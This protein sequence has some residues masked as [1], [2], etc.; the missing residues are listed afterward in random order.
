MRKFISILVTICMLCAAM[1][2]FASEN[3]PDLRPH[4]QP[5]F[6][7]EDVTDN[8]IEYMYSLLSAVIELDGMFGVG[9]PYSMWEMI[10]VHIDGEYDNITW[11]FPASEFSPSQTV[12]V[13]LINTAITDIYVCDCE[14]NE[15]GSLTT[16]SE[17]V[18]ADSY[19]CMV[20]A[21]DD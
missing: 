16:N 19:F 7:I 15:D 4:T 11:Y 5:R 14:I 13:F 10:I 1:T 21:S 20:L 6:V 8:Q 18:P 17:G 2:A 12:Y 3:S 9:V